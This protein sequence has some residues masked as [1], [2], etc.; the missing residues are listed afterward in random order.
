MEY[1]SGAVS[2]LDFVIA[3]LVT[4]NSRP[5]LPVRRPYAPSPA[6]HAGLFRTPPP[7]RSGAAGAGHLPRSGKPTEIAV[8][9]PPFS[10]TS[11]I[12]PFKHAIHRIPIGRFACVG[13]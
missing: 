2:T 13:S 6:R 4:L 9:A 8:Q 3:C 7:S 10:L 5:S 12:F 1:D 11:D